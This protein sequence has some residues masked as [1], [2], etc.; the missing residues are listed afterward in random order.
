MH[1]MKYLERIDAEIEEIIERESKA[2]TG[3]GEDNLYILLENRKNVMRWHDA[4]HEKHEPV[5]MH[6]T[7]EK[8]DENGWDVKSKMHRNPY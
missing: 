8:A 5:E 2:L 3:T 1:I 4:K 6:V 7:A